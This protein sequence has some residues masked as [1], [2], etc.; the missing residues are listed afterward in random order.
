M[1]ISAVSRSGHLTDHDDIGVLS[2]NVPQA[3]SEIQ[4]DLRLNAYLCDAFQVVFD[5][6]F[7]GHDIGLVVVHFAMAL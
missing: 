6:I 7:D 2:Q 5:G 1:A 3:C 4:L